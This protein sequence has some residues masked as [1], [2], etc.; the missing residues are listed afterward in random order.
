MDEQRA[1]L[2]R[3]RLMSGAYK[4]VTDVTFAEE[5]LNASQPVIVDFWAT[6]CQPCIRMAPI[7]EALATE[8]QGK[9]AFA[10]MDTDENPQTPGR[11]GIQG[12]PTMIVFQGGKEIDRIVGMVPR[13][14]LKRHLDS[15]L[16]AL[17]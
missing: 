10:K 4:V 15:A 2:P 3:R 13:E 17:A 16:A 1:V 11:Y 8:Y 7:F 5:V 6:W 9:I 12:I 14:V